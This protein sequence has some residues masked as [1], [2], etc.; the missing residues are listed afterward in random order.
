MNKWFALGLGGV[1]GIG[2]IGMIGMLANKSS[3]PAL[4]LPINEF[5]SYEVEANKEGYKIK[6]RA[7]DPKVM[8]VERDIKRKGGFLG[9]GNN[10]TK[11]RE[12]YT[13]EGSQH[14]GG[15]QDP[16]LSAKE[17]AC[18]KAKGG[19]EST[20]A[21]VGSGLGAAVAPSVASIPIVGWVAAGWV[22][23][24]GARQGGDIGGIMA[25]DLAKACQDEETD[26]GRDRI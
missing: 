21:V 10:T 19:G 4:N 6:Y 15:N 3:L 1:L 5:T 13:M 16:K 11:I 9:L 8:H 20:G 7:N 24:F 25:E 18:I 14:L 26:Q 23:M 22:T 12:Q 2:H 17:I